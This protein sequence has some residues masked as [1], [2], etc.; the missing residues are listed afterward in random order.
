MSLPASECTDM[1]SSTTFLQIFPDLNVSIQ[2]TGDIIN[3]DCKEYS[4]I[5]N[6]ELQ[7][8]S[9]PRN[10]GPLLPILHLVSSD[11]Q[12]WTEV[13]KFHASFQHDPDQKCAKW[14]P[15][16]RK[17]VGKYNIYDVS[18]IED[19]LKGPYLRRI[20]WQFSTRAFSTNA[21]LGA[22][23]TCAQVF[24]LS[25]S[26]IVEVILVKTVI[27]VQVAQNWPGQKI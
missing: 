3:S 26:R 4:N 6:S 22:L 16:S 25:I 9:L 5:F 19:N 7:S 15:R 20:Q 27:S 24:S 13:V 14:D 2:D 23:A 21:L 8:H 1:P 12:S 10:Q 18:D 17:L 11:S